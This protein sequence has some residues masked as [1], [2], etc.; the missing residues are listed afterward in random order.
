MNPAPCQFFIFAILS[1]QYVNPKGLRLPLASVSNTV[2]EIAV[3][4][5]GPYLECQEGLEAQGDLG[6]HGIHNLHDNTCCS[7]GAVLRFVETWKQWEKKLQ[8]KIFA[9]T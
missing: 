4:T 6:N 2:T 1:T 7:L 9:S 8:V 5:V 3:Q